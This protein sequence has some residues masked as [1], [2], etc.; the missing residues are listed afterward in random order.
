MSNERSLAA[1]VMQDAAVRVVVITGAGHMA[2]VTDPAL[3]E[4]VEQCRRS[5]DDADAMAALRQSRPVR[6]RGR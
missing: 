1:K 2:F 6:L 4:L 3:R 5:Q